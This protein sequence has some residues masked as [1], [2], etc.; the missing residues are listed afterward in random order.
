MTEE[1]LQLRVRELEN[2]QKKLLATIESFKRQNQELFA[3][4]EKL[5]LQNLELQKSL[6]AAS[7]SAPSLVPKPTNE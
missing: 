2:A 6:A 3:H 1:A 7:N 5:C 4:N